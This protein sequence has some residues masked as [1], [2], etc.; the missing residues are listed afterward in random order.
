MLLELQV[1]YQ[2]ANKQLTYTSN[3]TRLLG[4]TKHEEFYRYHNSFQGR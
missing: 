3:C 1:E 4:T 2:Q